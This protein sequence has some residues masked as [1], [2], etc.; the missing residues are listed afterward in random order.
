MEAFLNFFEMM[1]NSYK[2]GWIFVCL[3]ISWG[4]E[5]LAP[6]VRFEYKKW[7]HAAV[8]LIF[9][10]TSLV[11]NLLF[12]LATVGIFVWLA[13]AQFGFLYLIDLPIWAELIIAVMFLDFVAQYVAHYILHTVA[14]MWKFHMVHHSDTKVDATTGTRHHPGDYLIREVFSLAAIVLSGM[15]I[16]FYIFYRIATIFFAYFSHSNINMPLW[17]DKALSWVIITPNMH[18]FHHHFERPWTDTNFG[19]IFSFWDRIFGTLV[20]D[21]PRK[22]KYGLDVLD[23]QLDQDVLYQ[24]KVPFDKSIKTD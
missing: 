16:A 14:W 3:L 13:D 11:I 23:D 21:D 10:A 8:N 15:P 19:N 7:K 12:G 18:K 6:L 24:F 5:G 17:L 2:L 22:V 9:L 20:Y 4:I 1:S